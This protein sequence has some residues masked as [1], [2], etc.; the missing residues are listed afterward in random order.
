M[1]PIRPSREVLQDWAPE[2]SERLGRPVEQILSKGLSAHDFST[3]AFVEVRDPG[4]IVVRLPFAF[5][6]FRPA[7]ARVVV[8]TEHSGYIEFD[9]EEDAI[10]AEI[11]ERIYRQESPARNG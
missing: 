4:G 3:S 9:L 6:V 2:L 8:F 7:A 1:T 10:V 5:A 11:E